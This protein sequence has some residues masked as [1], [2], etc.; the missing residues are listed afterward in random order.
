MAKNDDELS[1]T[2]RAGCDIARSGRPGPCVTAAPK[3]VQQHIGT[4]KGEGLLEFRGFDQRKIAR[5][6]RK[7]SKKNAKDFFRILGGSNRPLIYAGGGIIN[8]NA[9]E[10]LR[11]FSN[12]FGIPAV[13][14]LM[15]IGSIDTTS[16]LSLHMLGM[17][18]TAYAN[19]AVEDCDFLIAIGAR[20]DDR[21]AGN[22]A[23]FAPKTQLI[24]VV[25][26]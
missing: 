18:G 21:V 13:T 26:P 11:E 23:E 1:A 22:V 10:A 20:F 5:E 8:S 17:H 19:Y 12:S 3:D 16:P 15:G 9:S 4:C 24:S 7:L 6:A 25:S 2:C 14:T